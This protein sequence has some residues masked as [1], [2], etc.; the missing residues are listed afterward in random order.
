MDDEKPQPTQ[1]AV[2]TACIL[3]SGPVF[4]FRAFKQSASR[5]LRG[6]AEA[7]F[8]DAIVSLESTGM[9]KIR[10]FRIPRTANAVTV[11]VKNE[12]DNITWPSNLY[13]QTEYRQ[14]YQLP[15]HRSVTP[16][17]KRELESKGYVPS[18]FFSE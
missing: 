1:L 3:F 8:R 13:S 4:T 18:G 6:I 11:F 14:R 17:I 2:K 7:E 10:S 5:S 16:A 9:G 12:P 15:T